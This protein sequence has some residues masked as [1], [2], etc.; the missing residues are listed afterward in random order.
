MPQ[1][2]T[3]YSVLTEAVAAVAQ[4]GYLSPDQMAYW[5]MRLRRA[6][7]GLMVPEAKLREIIA[8]TLS[9]TYAHLV[10]KGGLFKVHPGIPR[11]TV[12]R[13]K[14]SLRTELD[15]AIYA[16]ANLVVLN[17]EQRIDQVLR[18]YSGWLSSVPAG[19]SK[20]VD[21]TTV[22]EEIRKPLQSLPFEE[23]RVMV[24][25]GHKMVSAINRIVAADGGA[26]AAR[27]HSHWR[28]AGYD[29]REDHKDR[30]GIVYLVRGSWAQDKGL[31]KPGDVGYTDQIT[32]PGEEISCRC[33]YQYIYSLRSMPSDM[34][35]AKGRSELERTRVA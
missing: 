25:Q 28:Q 8:S 20:V 16:A 11:F 30:D 35:T 29:Y 24:D 18:R 22:K 21:R 3:F 27:W 19:G 14:P 6:A 10:D 33:S 12:D 23:R 9:A 31:V 2:E 4:N 7:E 1:R 32:Q 15:R 26:L 17:R 34:L 13:L 5:T